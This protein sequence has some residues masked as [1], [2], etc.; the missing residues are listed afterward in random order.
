MSFLYP[1][2]LLALLAIPVLILIYIIKNRYT[3]QTITS[4]YLWTLSERFLR[5]RIPIN[6]LSGILSL[7]LQILA[8]VLIALILAHPIFI[9]QGGAD[10]FCF[11][12]DGSGSMRIEQ[13]GSTRF[14]D[15]KQIIAEVIEG[16]R[17]GSTYTFINVSDSVY[18]SATF[19]DKE[20]ALKELDGLEASF[21]ELTPADALSIANEFMADYPG[22][23]AYLITDRTYRNE[24]ENVIYK[25]VVLGTENYAI[26]D[27]EYT[28]SGNDLIIKG[29][30]MSYGSPVSK[31]NLTV[32]FL[33]TNDEGVSDFVQTGAFTVEN[34]TSNEEEPATFEYT[35]P[36]QS[37][38]SAFKV[39]IVESDALAIDNEVVM[40][41][42]NEA[43]YGS[44]IVVYGKQTT[45][46]GAE[47]EYP[48]DGP[49][50]LVNALRAAGLK[51]NDRDVIKDEEY[52]ANDKYKSNYDLYI[53][54]SCVPS[55]M[56]TDGVVWF[57]NP[58]KSVEGANFSFQTEVLAG[59]NK[60]EYSTSTN[61]AVKKFLYGEDEND[62][63][64]FAVG[65][66]EIYKYARLNIT[67]GSFRE[68]MTCAGNAILSAGTNA[69]GNR[70][71][72]FGF[73]LSASAEFTLHPD[74]ILIT[75]RL[76]NYSFPE[77]LEKTDFTCG[78]TLLVNVRNGYDGIRI[79]SP[80]GVDSYPD[81]SGSISEYQLTEAGVYSIYLIRDG[82]EDEPLHVFAAMPIAERAISVQ[83]NR[84]TMTESDGSKPDGIIDNL[85]IIFIILAVISVADYGVYC[86][87]QYQLR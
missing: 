58:T 10:D 76:L 42:V 22:A 55:A 26:S 23:T 3:E 17:N 41:N 13:N 54:N 37:H 48:E 38:Y 19:T 5:K 65:G 52:E 75:R 7:L 46:I 62:D 67:G 86:Y 34:V 35:C 33:T 18:R 64:V 20:L 56:P 11:I 57:V 83:D 25:N 28:A 36:G 82:L 79:Q 59:G 60:A 81:I 74:C 80:S 43:N 14:D 31:L 2:G 47:G 63:K 12:L 51:F 44:V 30:V 71:V 39:S 27:V 87:E 21:A 84:F 40:Y 1:L 69:Y 49:R 77:V 78:E 61:S 24:P 85:L 8:V 9:V 72:I 16:S 29:T 68:Y 50:F 53:F 70:E 66:F 6:K 73:D 4:T 45:E 15:G 32:S